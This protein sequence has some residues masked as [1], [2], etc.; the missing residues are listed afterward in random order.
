MPLKVETH[1]SQ[2]DHFSSCIMDL[3][4]D[5]KGDPRAVKLNVNP[6]EAQIG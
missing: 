5:P 4:S 6:F 3:I 1:I 2:K